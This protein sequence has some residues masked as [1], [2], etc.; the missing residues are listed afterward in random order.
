MLSIYTIQD[1]MPTPLRSIAQSL[2]NGGTF[3]YEMD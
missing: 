1:I 3:P 2:K